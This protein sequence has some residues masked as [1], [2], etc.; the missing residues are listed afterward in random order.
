[1][2]NDSFI[3]YGQIPFRVIVCIGNMKVTKRTTSKA[4][5]L[6]NLSIL[7]RIAILRNFHL[8]RSNEKTECSD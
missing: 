5:Y 6:K 1:M 2:Y 4:C 3:N 8:L 7:R